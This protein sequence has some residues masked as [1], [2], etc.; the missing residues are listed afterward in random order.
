MFCCTRFISKTLFKIEF[1]LFSSSRNGLAELVG[2]RSGPDTLDKS[3]F[4][5]TFLTIL[6]VTDILFRFRLLLEGKTG[7]EMPKLLK[8]FTTPFYGWGSTASRLEPLWGG[9]VLFTT[10]FPEIPG[11]HFINLGIIK[12]WIDPGATQWLWT[13]V[14]WI[15]NPVP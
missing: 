12:G 5:M 14:P 7:K 4:I 15:W 10:K 13:W 1:L 8:N 2:I 6:E 9:S 3:R 11:T